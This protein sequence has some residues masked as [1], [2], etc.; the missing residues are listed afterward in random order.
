[1]AKIERRAARGESAN[2]GKVL[3]ELLVTAL[4]ADD[5]LAPVS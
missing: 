4:G 2:P 3:A 1:V 5:D